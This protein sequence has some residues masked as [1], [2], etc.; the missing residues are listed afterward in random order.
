MEIVFR[1][2]ANEKEVAQFHNNHIYRNQLEQLAQALIIHKLIVLGSK[3]AH[4]FQNN[5]KSK[6]NNKLLR[7]VNKYN[8]KRT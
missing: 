1:V 8:N 2:E 6:E 4:K 5:N 7:A 3:A